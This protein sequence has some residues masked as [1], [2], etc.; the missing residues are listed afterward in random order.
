[1]KTFPNAF[2]EPVYQRIEKGEYG[3]FEIVSQGQ[4]LTKREYFA[5]IAMQGIAPMFTDRGAN[6]AGTAAKH[7]VE[8]A[9]A[10]ITEL[11]KATS[12]PINPQTN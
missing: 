6:E 3:S 4:P 5:A 2:I 11:N 12:E 1:M 9:D 10:L 7:A 8:M